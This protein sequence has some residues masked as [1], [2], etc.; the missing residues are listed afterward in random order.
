MKED[1]L[2]FL[3]KH[4]KFPKQNIKTTQGFPLQ[5]VKQGIYNSH[6]GP[7]FSDARLKIDGL[8]WIGNV[9]IHV[10]SSDWFAHQ[11]HQDPNYDAVILHVVW[12]DDVP[13]MT[14]SG[15]PLPTLELSKIVT[16]QFLEHYESQ[17]LK[18]PQWIPCEEQIHTVDSF[19]WTHWKERL[20]IERIER[21]SQLIQELLEESKNNWEAVCFILLAKNFG[22]N[23]NGDSFLELSRALP[24]GVVQKNWQDVRSLEALFMGL[25]GMLRTPYKD[26]YHEELGTIYSYLKRKHKLKE[27]EGL[28]M[29]FSRLRP[30]N[31]PTIRWAQLAQLYASTQGVFSR[32]IQN[33]EQFQTAWLS[34]VRVSDYWKTHYVFG[35]SSTSKRK[36]LS[37]SF[38]E[39]LLINTVIPLKFTYERF[40]GNDPSEQMFDWAQQ[41][42]PEKNNIISGFEKLKIGAASA[43]DSQSLIELKTNY[44]ALKKCLNCSI[45]YTLLTPTQ[46][47]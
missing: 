28:G 10:Q 5:V 46:K 21:K 39:L 11:H 4:Q 29:Q 36:G 19:V 20:F 17:F 3:W 37:K 1:F 13:V 7:D 38:Q 44:C 24:F 33:E 40:K 41:L 8:D 45:G 47:K 43:L 35:K 34:E 27:L 31:F 22:L 42:A 12:E 32:F 15:T 26:P 25:S 18:R 16:R 14:E 23:V 30:M 2:H 9:E 6:A